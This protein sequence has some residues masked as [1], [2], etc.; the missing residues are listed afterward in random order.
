MENKKGKSISADDDLKKDKDTENGV[1]R[2]MPEEKTQE[3]KYLDG[4]NDQIGR[5]H[6]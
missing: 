2:S 6:V 3:E 4:W 1:D 5:A